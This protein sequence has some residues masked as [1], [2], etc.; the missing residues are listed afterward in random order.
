METQLEF[1]LEGLRKDITKVE[2]RVET[3]FN[4]LEKKIDELFA[5]KWKITGMV[6]IA[7]VISGG[8]AAIATA[9]FKTLI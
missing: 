3:R 7:S 2:T 6:A 1:I 4:Q 5:F 9:I 8:A